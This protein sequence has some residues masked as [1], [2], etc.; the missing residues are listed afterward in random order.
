MRPIA[1]TCPDGTWGVDCNTKLSDKTAAAMATAHDAQHG[2]SFVVRY[3]SL[4]MPRPG[5]ITIDEVASILRAGLALMLVQH[6]RLPGWTAT[7]MQGAADGSSAAR[8]A[9]IVGYPQGCHIA[10]DMEGLANS[11]SEVADYI[12][13]WA[14]AVRAVGYRAMVYVGYDAGLGA[15]ELYAIPG[16]D[17]YWSDM[18]GR[19]VAVRGCCMRQHAQTTIAGVPVD[20]DLVTADALGGLPVMMRDADQASGDAADGHIASGQDRVTPV[21]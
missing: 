10:V 4:G 13:Q 17:A 8:Q 12:T 7:G 11:G 18:A 14:A 5:D 21:A 19:Q 16:I 9:A 3:V 6:C 20:P 1:W 2:P 15:A